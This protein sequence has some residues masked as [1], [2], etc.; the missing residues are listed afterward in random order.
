MAHTI[1]ITGGHTGLGL[2]CSRA[3][4]STDPT[5]HLL[6]AGRSV[7]PAT[8]TARQIAPQGRIRVLPLDLASL[9]SV[10]TLADTVRAE[11]TAGTLP[12]LRTIVCNAGVQLATGLHRTAEGFE[13]TFGVNHLGH[14]LLTEMLLPALDEVRGRVVVVSSGT[15]FDAPRIWQSALFGMP[16]P[17]YLGGAA[18]AR[19]EVPAGI[20][21]T[22]ARANQF[23]Y[24]T[25]KLCNLFFAY[26]LDRRLRAA[27][28]AVTVNAFDPGLM[29][30][31][32]LVRRANGVAALWAWNYV[33]PVLRLFDGVNAPTTSGRHLA[34]L[35]TDPALNG[36]S[37]GY[38]EGNRLTPS[39]TL[40]RREE[41]GA[42]LWAASEMLVEAELRSA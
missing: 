7:G 39:S 5:F 16:A 34:W 33:M 20:Q 21:P 29:P 19:G 24:T 15:H 32:G 30:G 2:E 13:Q 4:L 26:E 11:L 3:L 8:A 27:G 10:R 12:P 22:S 6:W 38:Y 41:L 1:L 28:L 23:R 9:A 25:S 36:R 37:G 40:S 18:L 35:A 14:F 31:T 17:Q 42:D